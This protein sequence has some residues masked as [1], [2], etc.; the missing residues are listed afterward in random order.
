MLEGAEPHPKEARGQILLSLLPEDEHWTAELNVAD[1]GSV[2]VVN[3]KD[4]VTF[5]GIEEEFIVTTGKD[6]KQNQ[7]ALDPPLFHRNSWTD[8]LLAVEQEAA[9]GNTS[10]GNQSN[11][12]LTGFLSLVLAQ[13]TERKV[14]RVTDCPLRSNSFT[15]SWTTSSNISF[16]VDCQN[17]VCAA[18]RRILSSSN[19]TAFYYRSKFP[20]DI[21]RVTLTTFAAGEAGEESFVESWHVDESCQVNQWHKISFRRLLRG[22][23]MI[24]PGKPPRTIRNTSALSP[25][26]CITE[27][28]VDGSGVVTWCA[29]DEP[30]PSARYLEV[31]L[32]AVLSFAAGNAVFLCG[33]LRRKRRSRDAK[34]EK[35]LFRYERRRSSSEESSHYM[36][37]CEPP[38]PSLPLS[39]PPPLPQTYPP[40]LPL[41]DPPPLPKTYPPPLPLKD[42]PPLPQTYPP[43]LPLKGPPPLPPPLA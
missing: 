22:L 23:E 2:C 8:V 4:S 21:V 29:P 41:K 28:S 16:T 18:G 43:P 38:E 31:V 15:L 6:G 20:S 30:Q 10:T 17:K 9:V 27:V 34:G 1:S 24:L 42:P 7:S 39:S 35:Y 37:Y 33:R 5:D 25:D 13:G 40:P 14:I 3:L 12:N 19:A 11:E 36:R 26:F 32:S